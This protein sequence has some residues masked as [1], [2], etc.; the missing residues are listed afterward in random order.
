MSS[1]VVQSPS[2]GSPPTTPSSDSPVAKIARVISATASPVIDRVI[3]AQET[4]LGVMRRIGDAV[5][6]WGSP[7]DETLAV[8]PPTA[9]ETP[10]DARPS[11]AGIGTEARA[12]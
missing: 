6:R 2:P 10:T 9:T 4:S 12:T 1:P 5:R 7:P 11:T 8:A 3:G